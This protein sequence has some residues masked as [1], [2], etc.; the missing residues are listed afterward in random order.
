MKDRQ[1]F[2]LFILIIALIFHSNCK[3]SENESVIKINGKKI[4]VEVADTPAERAIGLS[5][6]KNLLE[7]HGVLFAFPDEARREFWMYKCNFDIDLAYIDASGVIR[8]IV[9]MKK[10]PFNKPVDSLPKYISSS[11]N[12]KF[13][14]EMKGDWFKEN[15]IIIGTRIDLRRFHTAY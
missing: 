2:I 3:T 4:K 14:L 6:R 11:S 10:E 5:Y 8:E 1:N 12:I 7:N 15:K 9:T 13:A